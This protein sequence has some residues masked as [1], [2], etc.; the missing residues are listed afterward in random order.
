MA[1]DVVADVC[2]T[3]QFDDDE[4]VVAAFVLVMAWGSGTSNPRSLRN[5]RSAL[6]D[7]TRAATALRDSAS[8]LKAATEI[9]TAQLAQVH[10]GF[11]LPGIQEAFFTKW[12]RFAGVNPERSWQPLILDSRVRA[13]L[14]KT[15]DVWLNNL[16]SYQAHRSSALHRLPVG[17]ARLGRQ[18]AATDDSFT[19]GV[20]PFH[21]QRLVRMT[22]RTHK[23][24][25]RKHPPVLHT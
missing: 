5:T 12:F 9:E 1:P 10:R 17:P 14:N 13:T 20:D 25:L 15:L 18:T 11:S 21:A 4:S 7:A 23:R 8:A 22:A 2:S 24:L 16:A 19:A 6:S 3:T